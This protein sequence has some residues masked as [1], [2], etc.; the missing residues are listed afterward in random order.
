MEILF[1]KPQI[2]ISIGS[3]NNSTKFQSY[4][5]A[6][7]F[8]CEVYYLLSSPLA[9]ADTRGISKVLLNCLDSKMTIPRL[10]AKFLTFGNVFL[11]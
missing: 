4:T 9:K 5:L 7:N 10:E 11:L 6:I 3:A 1:V 8:Y 2:E